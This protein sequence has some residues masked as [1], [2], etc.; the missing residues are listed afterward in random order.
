MRQVHFWGDD[1]FIAGQMISQ[2]PFD[3]EECGNPIWL[4]VGYKIIGVQVNYAVNDIGGLRFV[5]WNT[6]P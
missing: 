5:T 1:K 2:E 6:H 3:L 4:P